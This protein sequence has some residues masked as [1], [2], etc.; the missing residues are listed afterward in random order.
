MKKLLKFMFIIS[1]LLTLFLNHSNAVELSNTKDTTFNEQIDYTETLDTFDNP[2][3]GFYNPFYYNFKI[4]GNEEPKAYKLEGNLLHLRLGIGAFSGKVNRNK[5]IELSE[6][7][8]N[9]LDN[10]FKRIKENGATAIVRFAYDNFEGDENL[11]PSLDMILK[12]IKQICPI[13]TENKDVI[14]Y[15]ELGFFGPWGEMHTSDISTPANVT[16]ALNLMLANTPEEMKIG[17]RQPKYYVDFAG[18]DRAK[19]NENITVKGS[20]EYRVGLFNDGYLGSHSDLGTFV[21]R[22]VEISWLENQ[23]LHTL[24]GGEIVSTRGNE[25]NDKLNTAKYMSEEAFRTHTTYL[26]SDYDKK[27]INA[28]KNETYNGDDELYKGKDGYLYIANHLG[29]RFV[30]RNSNISLNSNKINLSLDIENVGFANLVNSKKVS[31]ILESASKKFE[32][33]TDLDPTTWN[34]KDT[35]KLNLTITIPDDFEEAEYKVYLRISKYGDYLNDNNYQ[36][37]R[38]ANNNIWNE[39]LGANYVG[40]FVY[41]KK[42]IPQTPSTIEP[43]NNEEN[44]G[45][46]NNPNNN[47]NNDQNNDDFGNNNQNSTIPE[48]NNQ[49]TQNPNNPNNQNNNLD[50]NFLNNKNDKVDN[51]VSPNN[52]PNTGIK[53]GL[54]LMII[55]S[56]ISALYFFKKQL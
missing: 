12:H 20:K 3:R 13:L 44:N 31:V 55:L 24:Y 19:L 5:D 2:E 25:E 51:T 16:Q 43:D 47:T 36:V 50:D 48:T 46:T 6:D 27:V 38:L 33:L 52:I 23:A 42:D 54:L 21:N 28:W 9:M 4:S 7:M 8:L 29:Y 14:S 45:Q 40:Q 32:L 34:T 49:E 26:N 17:V 15:I 22:E 10:I 53:K 39:V 18:V 35:S 30:L 37:I 11:E 1:L 41:N 56:S